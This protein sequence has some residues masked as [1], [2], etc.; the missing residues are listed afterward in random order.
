M[1][2]YH[3]AGWEQSISLV[4]GLAFLQ[5]LGFGVWLMWS[6][7]RSGRGSAFAY[8]NMPDRI[9]VIRRWHSIWKQAK[10]IFDT[11]LNRRGGLNG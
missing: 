6:I 1:L 4:F 10:V 7:W 5:S 8:A 11:L 9:Q 2:V 3:S